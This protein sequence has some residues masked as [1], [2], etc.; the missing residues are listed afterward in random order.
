LIEEGAEGSLI[1]LRRLKSQRGSTII[2]W[3]EHVSADLPLQN[4]NSQRKQS[5]RVE[6][7]EARKAESAKVVDLKER[8]VS[9]DCGGLE[10]HMKGRK[11]G[12]KAIVDQEASPRNWISMVELDCGAKTCSDIKNMRAGHNLNHIFIKRIRGR[13][14]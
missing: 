11:R 7:S 8:Y 9:M 13:W 14:R 3:G 1:W 10:R 2:Y 12:L 5:L 6:T 4:I